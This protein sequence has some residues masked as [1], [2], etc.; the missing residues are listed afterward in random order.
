[1]KL[2]GEQFGMDGARDGE[3]EPAPMDFLPE[4]D[5]LGRA[6]HKD[7]AFVR[8]DGERH[9]IGKIVRNARFLSIETLPCDDIKAVRVLF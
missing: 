1:M 9:E 3:D 2:F 4:R 8:S 5:G 6:C 7:G